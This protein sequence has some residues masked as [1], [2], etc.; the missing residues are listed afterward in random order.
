MMP[1]TTITPAVSSLADRSFALNEDDTVHC[2]QCH[3]DTSLSDALSDALLDGPR[4]APGFA[5]RCRGCGR[6]G[7]LDIR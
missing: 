6:Q 4:T 7:V 2:Y 5:V 3:H 1:R